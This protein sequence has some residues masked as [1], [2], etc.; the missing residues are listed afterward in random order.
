VGSRYDIVE[1]TYARYEKRD[2][3]AGL[4]DTPERRRF[5]RMVAEEFADQMEA[6]V[7]WERRGEDAAV[8]DDDNDD[9][10]EG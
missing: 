10:E 7:E 4:P 2:Q 8:R 3:Q 5:N 1:S 6:D 9:E